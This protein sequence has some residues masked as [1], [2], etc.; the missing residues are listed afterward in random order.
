MAV[1]YVPELIRAGV[2]SFKIEGR[3]KGPEYVAITTRAYRTAVDE[4]WDI[5]TAEADTLQRSF[6]G[7]D[8]A[9][10]QDLAQVF[11]RG[12]DEDFN[13]LSAGFLAGVKHQNL[14]RGNAP[15]HRGLLVGK[16]LD[17]STKGISVSVLGPIKRGDG[18]VFDRGHPE[19]REEGG[20][21]YEVFQ[22]GNKRS[23]GKGEEATAGRALLTFGSG[24]VDMRRVAVGDLIW[25]NKDPALDARLKEFV[26]KS[27]TQLVDVAIS[28][29]GSLGTPLTV[30]LKVGA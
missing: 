11:S 29:S 23:L 3:L 24:A 22:E 19:E 15:R 7:P 1:K 21:V 18:V 4:A 16:V 20:S 12:Q 26:E 2:R 10:L 9:S 25:R 30:A 6:M 14:V 8:P 13:G 5:L 28:V 17:V 27:D